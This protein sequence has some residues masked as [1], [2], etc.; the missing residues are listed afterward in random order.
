[1]LLRSFYRKLSTKIYLIIFIL[2]FLTLW[3]LLFSKEKFIEDYNKNFKESFIYLETNDVVK[4]EDK[5]IIN[6]LECINYGNIYVLVDESLQEHEI[7]VSDNFKQNVSESYILSDVKNYEFII[8]EKYKSSSILFNVYVSQSVFNQLVLDK[9]IKGYYISINNWID[10]EK[11]VSNLKKNYKGECYSF[12][13]SLSDIDYEALFTNINFFI[14][15]LI[16]IFLI[17][18][19]ISILYIINDQKETEYL[20]YVLGFNRKRILF[21]RYT[22]II[23]LFVFSFIISLLFSSIIFI[24]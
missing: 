17:L 19:V 10:N 16:I 8:K 3:C 2:L 12:N 22:N 20:Y 15:L 7:I 18:F 24:L 23:L 13:T 5:N 6:V 11:I 14:N 4:L 9:G 21:I 1:M